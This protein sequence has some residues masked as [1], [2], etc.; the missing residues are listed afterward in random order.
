MMKH[1]TKKQKVIEYIRQ[2]GKVGRKFSEI[3]RYI[4]EDL[5]GL[6]YGERSVIWS[7][8]NSKKIR[9]G[10]RYRGYWCCYLLGYGFGPVQSGF[11]Y[12]VAKKNRKTGRW[13]YDAKGATQEARRAVR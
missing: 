3:Q 5:N 4:V 2:A 6:D 8:T 7:T 12:R 13:V 10:K 9:Y 11:L 1:A